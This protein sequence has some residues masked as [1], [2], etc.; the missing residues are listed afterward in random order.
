MVKAIAWTVCIERPLYRGD[1]AIPYDAA[2][3]SLREVFD[4]AG[5]RLRATLPSFRLMVRIGG[6]RHIQTP[7]AHVVTLHH[8][9]KSIESR[10]ASLRILEALAHGFFVHEVRHSICGRGLFCVPKMRAR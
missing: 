7:S 10:H 9:T 2:E 3:V 1:G 4:R 6:G 8:R 5:V